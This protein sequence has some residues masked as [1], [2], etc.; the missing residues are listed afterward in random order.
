MDEIGRLGQSGFSRGH[1]AT[2]FPRTMPGRM[3]TGKAP[4]VLPL[5]VLA[6]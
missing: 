3:P 5:P 1:K 4:R 2:D 6:D